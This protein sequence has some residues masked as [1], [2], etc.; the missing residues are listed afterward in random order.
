MRPRVRVMDVFGASYTVNP[1]ASAALL[2]AVRYLWFAWT[3][4][5]VR[6]AKSGAEERI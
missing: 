1:V 3:S 5:A 6:R 2:S 4:L